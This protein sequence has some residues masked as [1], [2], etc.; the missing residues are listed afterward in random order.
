MGMKYFRVLLYGRNFLIIN[1]GGKQERRAFKAECLVEAPDKMSAEKG[2][3]S[4]LRPDE[5]LLSSAI[6][7]EADPPII[8]IE[9]TV[10]CEGPV[11]SG[12]GSIKYSFFKEEDSH[13]KDVFLEGMD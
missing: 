1:S 10:E 5:H 4:I 13:L 12:Q 7:N 2:A 6:N 3:L 8:F 11:N 9:K